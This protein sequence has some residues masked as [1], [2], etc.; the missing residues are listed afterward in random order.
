MIKTEHATTT[1][2][3]SDFAEMYFDTTL[4]E[5]RM[6]GQIMDKFGYFALPHF[7]GTIT[8]YE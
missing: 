4:L 6:V 2:Q 5:I 8:K 1:H 7:R 3:I